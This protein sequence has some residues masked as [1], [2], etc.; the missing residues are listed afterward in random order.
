LCDLNFAF[1]ERLL[2]L[3]DLTAQFVNPRLLL[4]NSCLLGDDLVLLTF[5]NCVLLSVDSG[6]R[7]LPLGER[8][9]E[10]LLRYDSRPHG[11]K[12]K[13]PVNGG[14]RAVRSCDD[15]GAARQTGSL[16]DSLEIPLHCDPP[17]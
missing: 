15:H 1:A 17:L 16:L 4:L 6:D 9:R 8:G 10:I 13:G 5:E 2:Q 14:G 12:P 11:Q 7:R 3:L